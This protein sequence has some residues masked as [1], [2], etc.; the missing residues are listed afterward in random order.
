MKSHMAEISDACRDAMART[1][2]GSKLL[3]RGDL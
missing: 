3:G 2:A 1:A